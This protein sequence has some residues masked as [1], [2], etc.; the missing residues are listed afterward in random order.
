NNNVGR[1][2]FDTVPLICM[3]YLFGLAV[4]GRLGRKRNRSMLQSSACLSPTEVSPSM[5]TLP[6][7]LSGALGAGATAPR[8]VALPLRRRVGIGFVVAALPD[9]D[10]VGTWVSPLFYLEHHRGVTHSLLMLP[11]WSVLLALLLSRLWRGG[12]G[13]RAYAGVV[14]LAL[15][16]HIVGDWLTSFGTMVFAPL[17][18][19][20]FALGTTF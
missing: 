8:T 19:A 4:A 17:S 18:D 2:Y 3:G 13:W 14:A 15:F 20:R 10:V 1:R 11:I 6:L 7:A 16:V 9:L 5:D 12:P